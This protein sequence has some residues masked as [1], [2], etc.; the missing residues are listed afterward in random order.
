MNTIRI[1]AATALA[2]AAFAPANA[3]RP[4]AFAPTSSVAISTLFNTGVDN[5]GVATTGNGADL[6]WTL[7]GGTAYTGGTNG[8]YPIGPWIA[9]TSVSRWITPTSNANDTAGPSFVFSETFSLTGLNASTATL[10]GQFA[11]DNGVTAIYLNGHQISSGADG[12]SSYTAFMSGS[13][14]FI[15]GTNVLTF[16]LRNDGGQTGLRVEVAGSAD[17][18]PE[19][20]TWTMMIAGFGLV[21]VGLRRRSAAVAA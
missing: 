11:G 20:A 14:N 21:G 4:H 16:N 19:A 7:A 13:S 8:V 6:H 10:S 1:A 17:A 5:A 12:F 9:E 3:Y 2:L 15:A 18:V